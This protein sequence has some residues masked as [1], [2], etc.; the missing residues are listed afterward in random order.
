M[1]QRKSITPGTVSYLLLL[2]ACITL[3]R[4]FVNTGIS[5]DFSFIKSAKDFA[6]TGRMVYNG[7][8]APILGWMLPLGALFIRL[9]GFSFTVVRFVS[10]AVAAVNGVL[11]Q[12]ILLR[13]GCTR[14]TALFGAGAVLLSPISWLSIVLFFSD[15]PGL[16]TILVTLALCIQ[17]VR[18]ETDRATRL[19]IATAFLASFLL[20][21]ARQLAWT[22]TLLMVP[23]AVWLV[24]KRKGI[25]PWAAAWFAIAAAGIAG[26][27]HWWNH[28]PYALIEPLIEHY[29]LSTWT[30]FVILPG[31][32]L[33]IVLAPVLTLFLVRR[34]PIKIYVV[35]AV[36]ALV[37]PLI[38]A[39]NPQQLLRMANDSIFGQAPQY[40][41]LLALAYAVALVPIAAR[42]TYKALARHQPTAR[43]REINLREISILIAPFLFV[44]FAL[45]STREA[46]FSRYLVPVMAACAIWLMKFLTDCVPERWG[47][48]VAGP[49]LVAIFCAFGVIQMHDIY[50]ENAATLSLTQWYVGQGMP[51]EQL[52]AGFAFDGSYQIERTG[53]INEPLIRVPKDAYVKRDVPRDIAPCHN[54]FLPLSPSIKPI[55]GIREDLANVEPCFEEPVLRSVEYSAWMAPHR[56]QM[57]LA[58]YKPKYALP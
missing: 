53:Y 30:R 31:M 57:F 33:I 40:V 37:V 39:R 8:S 26:V 7:W 22:S 13:L 44:L 56:R 6:D 49:A 5:D 46:F 18:A 23:S 47:C 29:P 4:P 34:V 52:E 28:Q 51:R 20:G 24:R 10:F 58:R 2:A 32:E 25:L 43:P 48:G 41:L 36:L 35:S 21:T 11:M 38:I 3:I 16:L 1:D 17:I 9:F 54:F 14:A 15:G 12:W 19:W 55:Y 45:V 50:R 27:M 42:I